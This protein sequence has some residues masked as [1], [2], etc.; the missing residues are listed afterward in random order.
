MGTIN[1]RWG[2]DGRQV[3]WAFLSR[4]KGKK[5]YNADDDDWKIPYFCENAKKQQ[6]KNNANEM[7]LLDSSIIIIIVA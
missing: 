5:N 2:L 3:R 6:K 1:S 4:E 7:R